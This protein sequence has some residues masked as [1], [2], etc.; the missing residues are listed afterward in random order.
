MNI[1]IEY[2]N[3][4]MEA[5]DVKLYEYFW[6]YYVMY[7]HQ[8]LAIILLSF[9]FYYFDFNSNLKLKQK[10]HYIQYLKDQVSPH[11]IL[12]ELSSIIYE[13]H[14][15]PDKMINRIEN[16]SD[17][18]IYSLYKIEKDKIEVME[19]INQ[20]ELFLNRVNNQAVNK[21]MINWDISIDEKESI[22]IPPLIFFNFIENAVKYSNIYSNKEASIYLS[23]SN[24]NKKLKFNIVNS[25]DLK[26]LEQF[27]HGGLGI[28][29]A[30]QRL[31]VF[32]PGKYELKQW[33]ENKLFN[34]QLILN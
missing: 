9:G 15:N 23:I 21:E 29:N 20:I 33:K 13:G 28:N 1:P 6:H 10:D 16:L 12:N 5:D 26:Y 25:I 17:W 11:Y 24:V 8:S 7:L 18:L 27:S 4:L 2:C 3:Q 30:I 22:Q 34:C 19:E 32:Y 31:E 14:K